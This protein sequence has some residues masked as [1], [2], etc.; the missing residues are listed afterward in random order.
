MKAITDEPLTMEEVLEL[1][2]TGDGIIR[3]FGM[4]CRYMMASPGQEIEV[5]SVGYDEATDI[6][7]GFKTVTGKRKNYSVIAYRVR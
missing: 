7:W 2:E 3:I 1:S 5:I 6:K 4:R